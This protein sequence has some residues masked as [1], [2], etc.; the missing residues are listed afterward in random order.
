MLKWYM[1]VR[2][3]AASHAT[4]T[5]SA[6]NICMKMNYFASET[7]YYELEGH[8]GPSPTITVK[9]DDTITFDQTDPSNWYHPI[10]FAYKPDGAHGSTWGGDELPEVEGAGELLYKIDGAP[11]TCADAG[12]TGL[13]CYEPEF[14]YPRGDWSAKSYTAELTITEDVA[15]SSYAG[16]IYYFCH[17]HS[18][19]SGKII[20]QNGDGS[21]YTGGRRSGCYNPTSHAVTN[22]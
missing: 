16:V 18:K 8:T 13:D 19:M 6:T 11:T 7:G 9:I 12:D 3:L 15:K 21:A 4:C 14:F 17:I 1:A 20:I 2:A 5:P 10:G 22:E